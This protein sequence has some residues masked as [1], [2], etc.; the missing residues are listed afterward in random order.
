[1]S[2]LS[3][4]LLPDWPA[5]ANIG[6]ATTLRF[7]GVSKSPFASLN[8]A[9]HVGDDPEAV[10]RNRY[11]I[12]SVLELPN[13]PIWLDQIHSDRVI[14]INN[15]SLLQQADASFTNKLEVVC[16]VLTADCLPLLI[17]SKDGLQV[18]AVHAGWKGL[19]AGV[20]S[21]TLNALFNN[22]VGAAKQGANYMVWLG[23]AIGPKCFEV[24]VEVLEAFVNKNKANQCA[25]IQISSAK[26]LADI[27]QLARI[28]LATLGVEDIYG[29]NAC[30]FMEQ[31]LY[32]SY[33]RDRQTG[34][35]ASL[36]WRKS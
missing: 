3:S 4:F 6:V 29:G 8:P 18:A 36:I 15:T 35:M 24:G 20:I 7:G 21:N 12:K 13:E 22:S 33:R 2:N 17:C 31:E 26:W 10:L 25:F 32:Y 16:A 23:P 28:E 14:E 30:T 11:F 9:L 19:A 5:P 1:M 34:R 27:Y